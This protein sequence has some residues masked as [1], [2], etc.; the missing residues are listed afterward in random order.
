ME[1]STT[2]P[3]KI[4]NDVIK[5]IMD[6]MPEASQSMHCIGWKYEEQRF[7]FRDEDGTLF[8]IEKPQMEAAFKLMFTDKWPKG[9][10]PPPNTDNWDLWD[11]WL[12]QSDAD[13]FDAF[14]QLA[15]FGEVI[16]G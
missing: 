15:C 13:S 9:L 2:I 12:C 14:V 11:E 4:V 1:L 3:E 5:N 8:V 6:N 7:K 10:T 16:Y